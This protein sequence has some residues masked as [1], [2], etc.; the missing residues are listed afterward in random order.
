MVAKDDWLR[1]ESLDLDAQGVAHAADGKVVFIDSRRI[2]E[3]II[4]KRLVRNV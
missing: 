3:I 1:V 2:G 4:E